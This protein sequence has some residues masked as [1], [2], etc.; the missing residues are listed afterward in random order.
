MEAPSKTLSYTLPYKSWKGRFIQLLLNRLV[1]AFFQQLRVQKENLA[2]T[3]WDP[4]VEFVPK[5]RTK[6]RRERLR[7]KTANLELKLCN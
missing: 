6:T 3:E 2:R 5:T 1:A 7:A 4:C